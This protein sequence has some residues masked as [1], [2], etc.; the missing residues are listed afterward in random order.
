M[1][2]PFDKQLELR[3]IAD[4]AETTSIAEAGK[5]FPVRMAG[6]FKAIIHVLTSSP[7]ILRLTSTRS[8]L[9]ST[10]RRPSTMSRLLSA[11][12]LSLSRVFM[13]SLFPEPE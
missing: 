4:G 6:E 5:S 7:E 2:G 10:A 9:M 13:K 3:D 11:R 8:L 1:Y 12:S